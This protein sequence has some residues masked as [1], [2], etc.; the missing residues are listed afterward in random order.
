MELLN[1]LYKGACKIYNNKLIHFVTGFNILILI[2][3]GQK[4]QPKN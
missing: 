1:N 4:K 2:K 3:D